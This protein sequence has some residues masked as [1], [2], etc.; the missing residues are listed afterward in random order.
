[1]SA[2]YP[3]NPAQ[4]PVKTKTIDSW[5]AEAIAAGT[6]YGSAVEVPRGAQNINFSQELTLLDRGTGDET[7]T[8]KV[9]GRNDPSHSWV[10]IPGL[11]FTTVSATSGY[12]QLPTQ[13][14]ALAMTLPR[15]VRGAMTTVGTTPIATGTLRMRY[16][17]PRGPGLVADHGAQ[18]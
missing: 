12:Q 18:S 10:D 7:Y 15:F 3:S 8:V 6:V 9:Q 14:N 5:A 2:L 11:A 16:T 1:M 4:M 17:A 13:A